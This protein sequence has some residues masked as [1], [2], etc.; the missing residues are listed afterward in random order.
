MKVKSEREVAQS[1]PTLSDLMDCS[2]PGSSVHGIFQAR[3][4]EWT[5]AVINNFHLEGFPGFPGSSAGKEC[6]CN[7]GDPGSIPG[8]GRCPGEGIGY[9][10][11]YSWA[12][13]EAQ[14]V[15]NPPAMPETCVSSMG[16]EDPLE[17]RMATHSGIP[18]GESQGQRNLAGYSLWGHKELDVTERLSTAHEASQVAQQ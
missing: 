8:L 2:P 3:V 5:W 6:A 11:Q 10:L 14:M 9:P 4:L 15:K 18:A 1:C 17:R 7:A 16:W 12:S 13:L